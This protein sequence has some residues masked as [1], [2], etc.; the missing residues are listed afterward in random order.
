MLQRSKQ[1]SIKP[2]LLFPFVRTS[3]TASSSVVVSSSIS[4]F[5]SSSLSTQICQKCGNINHRKICLTCNTNNTIGKRYLS[6]VLSSNNQLY[7]NNNTTN[8]IDHGLSDH[9]IPLSTSMS[10][11][12]MIIRTKHTHKTPST[13]TSSSTSPAPHEYP[14]L[15]KILIANRGEIACRIIRTAHRLGISTVAVYSDADAASA[16]VAMANEAYRIGPPTSADS[17]LKAETILNIA[18]LTNSEGIHPGYGFLSEN[19]NFTAN[20][21]KLGIKFIG[22]PEKAILDMGSKSAAKGIMIAAGVPVTPG[23]WENDNTPERL[24]KEA[25]RIGYPLMIKAVKG[26][27]G[28]GMRVV[29]SKEE[30]IPSLE[31]CQREAMASFGSSIVLLERYITK[32]RHIEFQ[33][34]A[35]TH[36]NAVYLWER[37]CSVQRRHQKVLEEAPAPFLS[38]ETRHAMG[39]AAVRA[40]LAVGYVGAGTVEFMLDTE[41]PKQTF[42]FMEMNTRLQVEHPVTEMITGLDLVEWQLR[43]ASGQ[44][45]P[46][47][48]QSKIDERIHGHAIEARVYAENPLNNFLP[49]T[50][51]LKHLYAPVPRPGTHHVVDQGS[52]SEIKGNIPVTIRVDTGVRQGDTVS[53][54]YD[55]MISKLI[56]HAKDRV[57]ALNAMSQALG[58]YRIAGLAHNL[59]FLRN[60]VAHPEF[61]KGAVDTSFLAQY[62]PECLPVPQ[63]APSSI[64][65]I[66]GFTH[67]Y[68]LYTNTIASASNKSDPWDNLNNGLFPGLPS[69]SGYVL[70]F[71]DEYTVTSKASTPASTPSPKAGKHTKPI[72]IH[73]HNRVTIK[74]YLSNTT[75]GLANNY[76]QPGFMITVGNHTNTTNPATSTKHTPSSTTTATDITPGTYIVT[77]ECQRIDQEICEASA[78]S[79][80]GFPMKSTGGKLVPNTFTYRVTLHIRPVNIPNEV[81]NSIV[82]S[83]SILV[84]QAIV[85]ITGEKQSLDTHIW[86]IEAGFKFTGPTHYHLLLPQEELGASSGGSHGKAT[87]IS[88]MPGKVI[89]VLVNPGDEVKENTPLMI[90]EAMKME[91][92][93][94]APTKGKIKGI[95]YKVGDFVQDGKTLITFETE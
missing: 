79:I 48:S 78:K 11:T 84:R 58:E 44:P 82:P 89:K 32:P 3:S 9:L 13:S 4:K 56:I 66:A 75:V 33:I 72:D 30:F 8:L 65:L 39:S 49:S 53:M 51:T 64:P 20:C 23:Y 81:P 87:V 21:A 12:S 26:G 19:P 59:S 92:V 50:G 2:N 45:L 18:K 85:V 77:G 47:I 1:L 90:L 43:I 55:P 28:K 41:D 71:Q 38:P 14:L 61:Q 46:I 7:I 63:P 86:P 80:P 73:A 37:D 54:F 16:F 34:I 95:Q 27:G 24:I 93:I 25:D 10:S 91:H 52:I 57:T 29:K 31:A 88:P 69:T 36:G 15:K 70:N 94:K 42:Y 40:A 35:D 83:N 74:P 68:H 67:A 76:T 60:V 5:S 62:L 17:Y 22:P 6:S